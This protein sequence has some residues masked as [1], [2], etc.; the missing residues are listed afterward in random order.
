M[1]VFHN[2]HQNYLRSQN[3]RCQEFLQ[4]HYRSWLTGLS[5]Q[6]EKRKISNI[7][8][9]NNNDEI[10]F[11]SV[12]LITSVYSLFAHSLEV[13]KTKGSHSSTQVWWADSCGFLNGLNEVEIQGKDLNMCQE[14]FVENCSAKQ[15]PASS[16][17]AHQAPQLTCEQQEVMNQRAGLGV[18]KET[19]AQPKGFKTAAPHHFKPS[20]VLRWEIS[21][22]SRALKGFGCDPDLAKGAEKLPGLWR[23]KKK[24]GELHVGLITGNDDLGCGITG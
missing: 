16:F 19:R 21:E 9:K 1:Q 5:L 10:P 3:H 24:N 20:Q 7:T 18:P 12:N 14:T 23:R 2:Y 8:Q 11:K 22:D 13:T 6:H 17:S 15:T 4:F